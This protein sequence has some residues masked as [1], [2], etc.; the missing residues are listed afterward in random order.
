MAE[1]RRQIAAARVG[2]KSPITISKI[3]FTTPLLFQPKCLENWPCVRLLPLAMAKPDRI[4][5]SDNLWQ[6][7]TISLCLCHKGRRDQFFRHAHCFIAC[8]QCGLDRVM[9]AGCTDCA[10]DYSATVTDFALGLVL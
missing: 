4:F 9:S 10:A 2:H 8:V 3:A 1:A 7:D 5:T 6:I